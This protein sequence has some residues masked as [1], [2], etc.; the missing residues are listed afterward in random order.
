MEEYKIGDT[1][2]VI[3]ASFDKCI[4]Y[5]ADII[6]IYENIDKFYPNKICVVKIKEILQD[7][8]IITLSIGAVHTILSSQIIK[9]EIK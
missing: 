1:V 2:I 7:D 3:Q 6:Q 5:L 9:K 4:K 8:G